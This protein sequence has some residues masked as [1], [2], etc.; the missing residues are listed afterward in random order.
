MTRYLIRATTIALCVAGSAGCETTPAYPVKQ[1]YTPPAPIQPQ[2]PVHAAASTPPLGSAQAGSVETSSTTGAPSPAPVE[3]GSLPPVTPGAGAPG[4]YGEP[5]PPA[6][7]PYT[8]PSEYAPASEPSYTPRATSEPVRYAAQGK[9]VTPRGMYRDYVVKKGDHLDAIAADFQSSRKILAEANHLKAPAYAIN[10]GQHIKV[11]VERA[12]EAQSGDTLTVIAKRFGVSVADL[13]DIN[14]L[15]AKARLKPGLL[16]A[17]PASFEDHG[18]VKLA[19]T[20]YAETTPTPRAPR[21]TPRSTVE[22]S[23]PYVPSQAALAAGAARRAE[24][25][26]PAYTPP[27]PTASAAPRNVTPNPPMANQAAIVTAGQGR[28]IWPVRGEIFGFWLTGVGRRNDGLDIRAPQG[29]SVHAAAAGDVVYAGD[30]VKRFRRPGPGETFGRLGDCLRPPRQDHRADAPNGHAGPGAGRG[31]HDRRGERAADPLRDPLCR[32]PGGQGQAAGSVASLAKI[33]GRGRADVAP[34][35]G[36]ASQRLSKFPGQVADELPS[37]AAR[38]RPAK[39]RPAQR[40]ALQVC[41]LEAKPLGIG[42]HGGEVG[43]LIHGRKADPQSK[44]VGNADLFLRILRR[45]DGAAHFGMIPGHQMPTIGGGQEERVGRRPGHAP[46]QSGFQRL[47]R[48][49]T[50]LERKV[51]A[52]HDEPLGTPAQELEKLGQGGH[53]VPIHFNEFQRRHGAPPRP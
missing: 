19:A 27:S 38:P 49:R 17:L 25:Q 44:A 48:S 11:P 20:S 22:E 28:F 35:N 33:A 24:T 36:S 12:Y 40:A 18:P 52:E 53:R 47:G 31:G 51:V 26:Q 42:A 34:C 9:V 41:R 45:G 3:S 43:R 15:S 37:D 14:N 6:A 13:S 7:T 32:Q 1:G 39:L 23:G 4:S 50:V 2:Y 21:R 30:Q 8:P 29:T 46:L 10:P 16:V 5:Q